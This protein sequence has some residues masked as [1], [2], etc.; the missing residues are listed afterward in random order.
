MSS[1]LTSQR[2]ENVRE[3]GQLKLY[4]KRNLN[5]INHNERVY[6]VC[7]KTADGIMNTVT[8]LDM[9]IRWLYFL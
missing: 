2:R 8:L 3:E 7:N 9:I 1:K 6:L 5:H 4:T